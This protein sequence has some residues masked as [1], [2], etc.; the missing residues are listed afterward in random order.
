MRDSP[1]HQR[2]L[3]TCVATRGAELRFGGGCPNQRGTSVLDALVTAQDT[4][5]RRPK[6]SLS[7]PFRAWSTAAGATAEFCL[8]F[9]CNL[10]PSGCVRAPER[11]VF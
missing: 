2:T 1:D 6:F 5:F 3:S 9:S 10:R 7:G 4:S 11:S 8:F